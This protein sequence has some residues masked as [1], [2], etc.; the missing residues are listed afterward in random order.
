MSERYYEVSVTAG[1][2]DKLYQVASVRQ[3]CETKEQQLMEQTAVRDAVEQ[4][5]KETMAKFA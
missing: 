3:Y 4:A 1:N 2:G 5:L